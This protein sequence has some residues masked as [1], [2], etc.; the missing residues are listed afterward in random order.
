MTREHRGPVSRETLYQMVWQTPMLK[1]A[2]RFGVSSSYMA[3][4]CTELRVPRP[5]R[6]YWARLE[7]G[8]APPQPP[9][10]EARLGD[11]SEWTPGETL[12]NSERTAARAKA[13]A[14][15]SVGVSSSHAVK[16]SRRSSSN[17]SEHPLLIGIRTQLSNT[18]PSDNGI[19]RP[20]KRVLVDVVCSQANLDATIEAANGLFQLLSTRGHRVAL[21]PPTGM[22]HRAEVDPREK[23]TKNAYYPRLWSPYRPTVVYVDQFAIGLTLFEMIEDVQMLAMGNGKYVPVRDLEGEQRRRL[24]DPRYWTTTKERPSGRLC[25]QAYCP[26]ARVEWVKRWQE[27]A[28]GQFASLLPEIAGELEAAAPRLEQEL[29]V[30]KAKAEEEHRQWTEQVRRLKEAEARAQQEKRVK[31]AR[32]E[33]LAAITK[34]DEARRLSAFFA[35]AEK[36]SESLSGSERERALQRITQAK[37]LVGNV[38]PLAALLAWKE[39]KERT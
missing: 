32:H 39:P 16:A 30:A 13:D 9:L 37:A 26:S 12:G 14:P 31:E 27:A 15:G 1:L 38:D 5:Q 17:V 29:L 20:F 35:E 19:L 21:A 8:K 25:L 3:R 6:G 22:Y 34:W 10:P 18:R 24:H 36:S 2:E 11:V 28:A 7:F 4:V 23:P 33:L